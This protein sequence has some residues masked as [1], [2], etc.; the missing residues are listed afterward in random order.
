MLRIFAITKR[1]MHCLPVCLLA[2]KQLGGK[3]SCL[4]LCKLLV[5]CL[6]LFAALLLAPAALAKA[7]APIVRFPAHP[8]LDSLN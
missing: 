6:M 4:H 2:I 8:T 5:C 3:L 1:N 7:S